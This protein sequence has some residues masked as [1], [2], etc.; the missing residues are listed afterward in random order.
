M[1]ARESANSIRV[2][3]KPHKNKEGQ[4]TLSIVGQ[5]SQIGEST[6]KVP[7]KMEGKEIEISFNAKYI[8]D[9]L[10]N[11]EDKNIEMSFGGK[12]NP[13]TIKGEG[14]HDYLYVI[15]PLRS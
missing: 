2:S 1:F 6:S 7:V 14:K 5:G 10:S 12:I 9:V 15:M 4:G 8:L 11:I 3:V 13:G